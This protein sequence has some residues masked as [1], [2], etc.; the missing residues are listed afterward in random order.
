M[1]ATCRPIDVGAPAA[2]WPLGDA[3]RRVEAMLGQASIPNPRLEAELIVGDLLGCGRTG[4]YVRW[5][6]LFPAASIDRILDWARRRAN[7]EPLQYLRGTQEFCSRSFRVTPDVLIPRSETETLVECAREILAARSGPLRIV[8]V[9][10]GSGCIA[11]S[12]ERGLKSVEVWATDV[13]RPAIRMARANAITHSS[14]VHFVECDLLSAFQPG[15]LFDAIVSN[16]PY[17]AERERSSLQREVAE[18]EPPLALF[19]GPDGLAVIRRLIAQ[20]AHHLRPDGVFLMEM[21]YDQA[22]EVCRLAAEHG[23]VVVKVVQDLARLDRVFV[24]RRG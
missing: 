13:S 23:L 15:D 18:H 17:L 19:G 1:I 6:D 10:T 4:V 14:N 8:D 9:G 3:V 2:L 21:A 20:A 5:N 12:L 7:R 16:P 22:A 11:V 24:A